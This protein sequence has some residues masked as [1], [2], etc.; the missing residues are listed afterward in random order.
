VDLERA[1]H[2]LDQAEVIAERLGGGLVTR[3]GAECCGALAAM[4]G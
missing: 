2:M 3:E 4:G 1:Q